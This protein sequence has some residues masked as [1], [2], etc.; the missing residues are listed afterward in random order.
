M[1]SKTASDSS[2]LNNIN[3]NNHNLNNQQ[4]NSDP[5]TSTISTLSPATTPSIMEYNGGNSKY[6]PVSPEMMDYQGFYY[7]GYYDEHGVLIV[8][9]EYFLSSNK[10]PL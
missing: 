3:L 10:K 7:P 8:N 1:K 9:R 4:N 2:E 5:D 6:S